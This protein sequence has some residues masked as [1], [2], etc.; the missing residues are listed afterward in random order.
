MN[1]QWLLVFSMQGGRNSDMLVLLDKEESVV[2]CS[3]LTMLNLK[4]ICLTSLE[5]KH[6]IWNTPESSTP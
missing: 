6:G 1:I 5:E 2:D 3:I 4:L